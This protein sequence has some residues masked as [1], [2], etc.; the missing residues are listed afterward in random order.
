MAFRSN[1]QGY[2][3]WACILYRNEA[4]SHTSV[5]PGMGI[6]DVCGGFSIVAMK[7]P[8]FHFVKQ[9]AQTRVEGDPCTMIEERIHNVFHTHPPRV[10]ALW[11]AVGPPAVSCRC[12]WKRARFELR[13]QFSRTSF[14]GKIM[15]SSGTGHFMCPSF[16]VSRTSQH[17]NRHARR[18]E[19]GCPVH[20]IPITTNSKKN[21]KSMRP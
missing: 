19:T 9:G 2:G 10:L 3:Q 11:E 14:P 16:S 21:Q 12:R 6:N 5:C 4:M 7:N 20:P 17:V 13:A 8:V 18:D 1:G 15:F